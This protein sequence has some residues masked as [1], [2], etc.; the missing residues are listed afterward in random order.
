M[1]MWERTTPV[2]RVYMEVSAVVS[3]TRKERVH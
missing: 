1:L 2:L 3:E